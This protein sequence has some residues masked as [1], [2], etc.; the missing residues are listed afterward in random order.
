MGQTSCVEGDA[1]TQQAT[2]KAIASRRGAHLG[3]V[4]A[5]G[6]TTIPAD[7]RREAGINPGDTLRFALKKGRIIVEK[8]NQ[9]DITW[10]AGQSAM[11][12]EWD[13]PDEDVYND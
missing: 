3:Y 2:P 9:A 5:K 7:I 10:N 4:S 11:M 13:D 6:Q 8:A 12:T 1:V